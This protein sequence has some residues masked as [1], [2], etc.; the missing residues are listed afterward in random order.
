M[1][2]LLSKGNLGGKR[3]FLPLV[4]LYNEKVGLSIKK[5]KLLRDLGNFIAEGEKALTLVGVCGILLKDNK[6]QGGQTRE[7]AI[8]SCI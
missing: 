4:I 2:D 6:K 3:K 5:C 7:A 1:G 8:V